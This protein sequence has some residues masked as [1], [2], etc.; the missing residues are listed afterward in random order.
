M[1]L[2]DQKLQGPCGFVEKTSSLLIAVGIK[3]LILRVV[4]VCV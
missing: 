4:Y 1:S 3:L 2:G